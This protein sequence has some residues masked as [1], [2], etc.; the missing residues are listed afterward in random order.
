M[1]L[2]FGLY[3]QLITEAIARHLDKRADGVAIDELRAVDATSFLTD[4]IA[5]TLTDILDDLRGS[6]TDLLTQQMEIVNALIVKLRTFSSS[7]ALDVDTVASPLRRL[8]A[9]HT[10]GTNAPQV[11]VTRWGCTPRMSE[12]PSA[13]E[14][15]CSKIKGRN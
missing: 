8:R 10:A 6:E 1:S 4:L 5:R 9:I 15:C 2:P 11:P 14:S 12:K 7:A 3:D 13:K